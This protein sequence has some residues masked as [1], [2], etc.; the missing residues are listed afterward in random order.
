MKKRLLKIALLTSPILAL[1]GVAPAYFFNAVPF[2]FF[3]KVASGISL[4]IFLFWNINI[5]IL[6]RIKNRHSW[7]RYVLSYL[8][9]LSIDFVFINIGNHYQI[10]PKSINQIYPFIAMISINTF[11]LFISN[12]IVLQY[13]KATADQEIEQLKVSNLEAQKQVLMQQLQPHF[14]FNALS[15]LKSL[16]SENPNGAEDYTLRLSEFLRYSIQA[17][18]N[19][20][21]NLDEEL[22]FTENYINLQKVRFGESL[23][24]IVDVPKP[25]FVKKLPVYGLQ[26][27]VENAIKHNAF[28]DKKILTIH[29]SV[30]QDRIRVHNNRHSKRLQMPSGTGLQNLNKRFQIL[31]NKEIEVIENESSFV[32]YLHILESWT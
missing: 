16:I 14:L 32:V 9:V 21:I 28:S 2:T 17:K 23:Q 24:F 31:A 10:R 27:L 18:N 6:L 5:Q 15:T 7:Q 4:G 29:I 25:Y 3:L 1:Y 13:Q 12:F 8:I 20:I 11:I 22:Q 26:T 19:E 30:E